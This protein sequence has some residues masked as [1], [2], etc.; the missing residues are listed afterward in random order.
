MKI[1]L[2]TGSHP[3]HAYIARAIAATN[4]LSGLVI[5]E[6]EEHLPIAPNHL[7]T[8]MKKM[9]NRHFLNRQVAGDKHFGA[10]IFPD[11][12]ILKVSRNRLNDEGTWS[13]L[14]K[15]EPTL[16]LSYGC[17]MLSDK[18]LGK[19]SGEIWNIHGGLS[20]WY[21]GAITHFWP[22]YMLEPQMTGMTIHQLTQ[23]LDAGDVVHQCCADL[24][25]GDGIHDLAARAVLKL[26]IELPEVVRILIETGSINK[27]AHKTAGKLWLS[28]DW[29]P[30][31]LYLIYELYKD[32]IVDS[33]LNEDLK[34]KEPNIYQQNIN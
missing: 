16:L 21:R 4:Y 28:Q 22:S 20:P 26:A 24:V 23:Q 30:E 18:T 15:H 5:E 14:K 33:Y 10:C 2:I 11:V 17:H 7:N 29:R 6:R 9:F 1:I 31:H 13:F 25:R 27:K 12:P 3:Q 34:Q 8:Q 19:V 32:R